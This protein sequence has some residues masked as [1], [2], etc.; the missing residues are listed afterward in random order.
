MPENARV[1]GYADDIYVGFIRSLYLAPTVLAIGAVCHF[2]VGVLVYLESGNNAYLILAAFMGLAGAIRY[3]S[4]KRVDAASILT[5]SQ[6]RRAE[7]EYLAFGA[8]QGLTVG[9]FA[10]A[11]IHWDSTGFAGLAAA[12]M[13][14]G[15]AITIAGR[16]YGSAKMVAILT[17]TSFGLPAIAFLINGSIYEVMIALLLAPFMVLI[18]TM[19][20]LVRTALFTAL[21]ESKR[22]T[23]LA[24]RLNRALDTMPQ[25]LLMV[26]ASGAVVVANRDAAALFQIDDPARMH[27][28]QFKTLFAGMVAA[29]MFDAE[30]ADRFE[31]QIT[32]S[33]DEGY[34]RKL[35]MDIADGRHF[36]LTTGKGE[37][38]LGVVILSDV[39][40]R[41]RADHKINQMARF[42]HLTGLPNRPFFGERV[43]EMLLYG[44]RDR[45]VALAV[46]DLDDF[47]AINDSMGQKL[48]D[49]LITLIAE[50]LAPVASSTVT[51]GRFGGDEFVVYMDEVEGPETVSAMVDKLMASLQGP[52]EIADNKIRIQLSGGVI[53]E[54]AGG[55]SVSDMVVKADLALARAKNVGKNTWRVFRQE[56]DE[57]FRH[58]QRLK[59]DL[60][61]AIDAKTLRVV[62]QPIVS[63]SGLRVIG[64]EALCRWDHPELGAISPAVFIPLA[65][66]MGVIAGVT[67]IVLERACQEAATWPEHI[68]ISVNLSAQDFHDPELASK[69]AATLRAAD[70]APSRLE[71][72]LTESALLDDN[73]IVLRQVEELRAAGIKIALDDF[74]TG[75]SSL[76]YL[77]RLPLNKVKIDR[78]FLKNILED[79]HSLGLLVDSVKLCR[80]LGLEVTLEGVETLEQLKVISRQVKPDLMQGFLFG[81]PLSA[82]GIASMAGAKWQFE[83]RDKRPVAANQR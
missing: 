28:M 71:V 18:V 8:F 30:Q 29:G 80:R 51:I 12:S 82:S 11:C 23:A 41:V 62:F 73:E 36:E 48:G 54:R 32:H 33:L 47:K 74:G 3:V 52:F 39:T 49:G 66:E 79:S 13:I 4:V 2:I 78:S 5:V 59:S 37:N 7:N 14:W 68:S 72:E 17:V 10:F 44:P 65:E 77:N 43:T 55:T 50:R 31:A 19:A 1:A 38:N 69:V 67:A 45:Q 21:T 22:A 25:A 76:S 9:I 46:L 24:D 57:S 16:N 63:A 40:A 6:A 35:V 20:K 26:D 81:P 53:I 60:R 61:T 42:D 64:C 70:L 83:N 27:G 75:Y 56:M 34:D 58:R 15:G